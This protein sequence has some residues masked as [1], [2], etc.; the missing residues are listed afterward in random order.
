[1]KDMNRNE[2]FSLSGAEWKWDDVVIGETHG[3]KTMFA[4]LMGL[5][6]ELARK[7]LLERKDGDY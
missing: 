6:A 7:R 5:K 3:G 4:V 1:M 2:P